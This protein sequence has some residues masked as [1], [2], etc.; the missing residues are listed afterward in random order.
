M[1]M[2]SLFSGEPV[3]LPLPDR[4]QP[5]E[6]ADIAPPFTI[7]QVRLKAPGAGDSGF[8]PA[9]RLYMD[10]GAFRAGLLRELSDENLRT[11]LAVLACATANGRVETTPHRVADLLGISHGRARER[12]LRLTSTPYQGNTVLRVRRT[13]SGLELFSPSP[14]VLATHDAGDDREKPVV[15]NGS[16]HAATS[17][18]Q[19]IIEHSRV[20]HAKPRAE[21]EREVLKQLGLPEPESFD[22]SPEGELRRRLSAIGM[23]RDTATALIGEF[24]LDAVI[25]QLNWLPYRG[26]KDPA[27]YLAAAVRGH[28]AEPAEAMRERFRKKEVMREGNE[29][30]LPIAMPSP[31]DPGTSLPTPVKGDSRPV[32]EAS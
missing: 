4:S 8:T 21:V 25:R 1:P 16:K 13:E 32:N 9:A 23:E 31:V 20:S 12:L 30:A 26:A 5:Q 24:G 7:E 14:Q 2:I 15:D 17:H 28:Y 29:P 27:R 3:A 6:P 22:E 19:A 10:T 11:L 18:R